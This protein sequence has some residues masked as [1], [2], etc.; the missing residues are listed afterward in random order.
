MVGYI[1]I[2]FIERQKN[3][4]KFLVL[5]PG[6]R[7]NLSVMEFTYHGYLLTSYPKLYKKE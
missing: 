6:A 5:G 4:S 3:C 7:K 1:Y 2:E